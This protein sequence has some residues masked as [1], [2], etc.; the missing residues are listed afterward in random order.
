MRL[1]ARGGGPGLVGL[2]LEEGAGHIT[3]LG[4]SFLISKLGVMISA[5]SEGCTK[6]HLSLSYK[7]PG[8]MTGVCHAHLGQGPLVGVGKHWRKFK[9]SKGVDQLLS[10]LTS[11]HRLV[12][13]TWKFVQ[14]V[15]GAGGGH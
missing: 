6:E 3:P 2:H 1:E 14:M 13:S 7:E 15:K 12:Q 8:M 9:K 11:N 10:Y 4:L 5:T